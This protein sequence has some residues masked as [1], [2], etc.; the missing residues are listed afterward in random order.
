MNKGKGIVVFALII[1][2]ILVSSSVYAFSFS[3]VLRFFG[4]NNGGDNIQ[5]SS[6]VQTGNIVINEI[7]INPENGSEW[8]ELYN[9]ENN[10]VNIT[11]WELWEGVYGTSG[12]TS[13]LIKFNA[14]ETILE[15][16]SYYVVN[17]SGLN[18][19]GENL[20]IYNSSQALIDNTP[21]LS[22]S[23]GDNKTWQRSPNGIDTNNLSDWTFKEGTMEKNND[24]DIIRPAVGLITPFNNSFINVS[25]VNFNYT[26]FDDTALLLNCTLYLYFSNVLKAEESQ[27]IA[28][29]STGNFS[30]YNL[31]DGNYLWRV[32]C[33]DS[34]NTGRSENR[35]FILNEPDAPVINSIEY[36]LTVIENQTILVKIN[37]SDADGNSLNYSINSSRFIED[38]NFS[39]TFSWKTNFSDAGN[40]SFVVRVTDGMFNTT[41]EINTSVLNNNRAPVLDSIGTQMIKEDNYSI[42]GLNASDVDND[43][44]TYYGASENLSQVIC[45]VNG[46]NLNITGYR[47]FYGTT[48]CNVNVTDGTDWDSERFMIFFLPENDAPYFVENMQNLSMNETQLITININASDVDGDGVGAGNIS[49][50]IT[51]VN[52]SNNFIQDLTNKNT[53]YWQTNYTDAGTYYFNATIADASNATNSSVFKVVVNNANQLPILSSL[54]DV[55]IYE[56]SENNIIISNLSI[57]ASDLDGNVDSFEITSQNQSQ[58]ECYIYNFTTEGP[59]TFKLIAEPVQDFYGL[60]NCT[61]RA[62]DNENGKGNN[63]TIRINVTNVNDAPVLDSVYP[64]A[65]FV[66]LN[67]SGSVKLNISYYD[68]D[69]NYINVSWERINIS[70]LSDFEDIENLTIDEINAEFKNRTSVAGNGT[71]YTFTGNGSYQGAMI[72]AA[73]YD[74]AQPADNATNA[75]KE[76]WIVNHTDFWVWIVESAPYPLADSYDG[77]TTNFKSMNDSQL[78][79]TKFTLE[80]TNYGRIDYLENVDLRNVDDFDFNSFVGSGITGIDTSYYTSLKNKNAKIQMYGLTYNKTPTIYY[81][82]AFT[83]NENDFSTVCP[84]SICSNITYSG[85]KLSFYV[86]GFS[87]YKA[88][89]VL[90]CSAQSGSI[91]GENYECSSSYVDASDSD[92]CCKASCVYNY[93][94]V[95]SCSANMTSSKIAIT[96]TDPDAKEEF[97]VGE[98]INGTINVNNRFNDSKD[99]DL[100]IALYDLNDNRE[101]VRQTKSVSI[102]EDED[103]D[104]DFSLKIPTNA[105]SSH[106]F[107]IHSYVNNNDDDLCNEKTLE[108]KINKE[109]YDVAIENLNFFPVYVCGE[110]ITG[111]FIIRNTGKNNLKD[112]YIKASSEFGKFES[113]EFDLDKNKKVTKEIAINSLNASNKN[114]T[115]NIDVFFRDLKESVKVT[116][117]ILCEEKKETISSISPTAQTQNLAPSKKSDDIMSN[118]LLILLLL[119]G[120]TIIIVAILIVLVIKNRQSYAIED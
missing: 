25:T 4:F 99:F 76:D 105:D 106:K 87:S 71:E 77:A 7:E 24:G 101:L 58:V 73:I 21:T 81:N 14:T 31:D 79:N 100:E 47:N 117:P 109:S 96:I 2:L 119:G 32:D 28:N 57:Y 26:A 22:D 89:S 114:Y 12:P 49:Y 110:E 97:N 5:I 41:Q 98:T 63:S 70:G 86:S 115:L 53:F 43:V 108:I 69:S 59:V 111:D 80:R 15:N 92:R 10:P 13:H 20:T 55:S 35:T 42:I 113:A 91:C 17:V 37:A 116:I 23:L 45:S 88:G 94:E 66:R 27:I 33:R 112:V 11:N 90:S 29:G 1:S 56:D 64:E 85:G 104:V 3:D 9:P 52:N 51:G 44:L 74:K 78:S 6:L 67:E 107:V 120:I 54:P 19:A 102:D 16:N 46:L 68:I 72:I 95:E 84:D 39:N 30:V 65:V 18:N 50:N 62:I 103:S 40:Y 83:T 36:N 75:T 60:A 38:S 8:V 61:I 82:S 34:R 48:Y 93:S 118:N